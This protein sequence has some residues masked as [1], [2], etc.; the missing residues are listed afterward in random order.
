M[1]IAVSATGQGMDSLVDPRFGRADYLL[2]IETDT[3]EVVKV[4]DNRASQNAAHGAGI[5]AA[6]MVV[7]AGVQ[8]LLT[9]QVG[10]KAFAVLDAAGVKVFSEQTGTVKEAVMRFNQG[11]STS[12]LSPNANGHSSEGTGPSTNSFGKSFGGA[13]GGRGQGGGGRSMGGGCR[14][15]GRGMGGGGGRGQGRCA[16][17]LAGMGQALRC[18]GR[19]LSLRIRRRRRDLSCPNVSARPWA[20]RPVRGWGL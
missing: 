4:I 11:N 15:G 14:G 3:L 18:M 9:G 20:R 12:S 16:A 2:I 8:A 17:M 19:N 7:D 1:Q 5:N 10:P 6:S 13:G